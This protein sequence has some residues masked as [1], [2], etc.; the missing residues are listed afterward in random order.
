M[1]IAILD[2]GAQYTKVIDRRIRELKIESDIVAS[3]THVE[4]LREYDALILS[5]GPSS[6]YE[7]DAP[8]FDKKLFQ[9]NIPVLGICYGMQLMNH[10]LGGKVQSMTTKEYGETVINI[11][12]SRLFDGLNGEQQVLMSH[13]DSVVQLAPGFRVIAMSDDLVAGIEHAEKKLYGVQ[14][15]PEVDLTTHGKK[16]LANFVYT[17]CNLKPTFTL[18]KRMNESIAEI[19]ACVGDRKVLVLVSGGVDSAVTAALLRK[20]LKQE[21]IYA[22]HVDHGFMRKNESNSV[23]AALERIGLNVRRVD[24]QRE[25]LRALA[26]VVEPEKKRKIIGDMFIKIVDREIRKLKLPKDTFLA[27]GTL[28][29]DLI[30]SASSLVSGTA[31]KIKTHHNDSEL[32]RQRRKKGFVI[33]PNKDMHKDEVREVGRLLGLPKEI[34]ERQPFPGPGL[35]V[36]IICADLVAENTVDVEKKVKIIAARHGF[37]SAVL[38]IRSVG[39]QGDHRSYGYVAAISGVGKWSALRAAAQEIPRVVHEVNRVVYL[40][41]QQLSGVSVKKTTLTDEVIKL[42]R[43]ADAIVQR[44]LQ[45]LNIS[46]VPV[47]LIPVAFSHGTHSV[48]LR[49]FMTNDFMTGRPAAFGEIPVMCLKE[50]VCGVSKLSGISAVFYDLTSK[51]PAT[52]EWE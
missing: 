31:N 46:Q 21:Q 17:I 4:K 11:R 5:G 49:P 10:A 34:T 30:E 16:I 6:V 15:H 36:R 1:V 50:I 2:F 12:K 26:G 32:V 25:F 37:Q 35:A 48:V 13:G 20:A 52:T 43:E 14:F 51:P 18:S 9:L 41:D 39:V 38:P 3:D 19:R 45:A 29:P 28:R 33:E 27:Q 44:K 22:I 42:L 8:Q 40:F 47:I 7:K 23:C 24:A